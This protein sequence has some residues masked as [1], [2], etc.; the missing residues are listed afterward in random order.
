MN[1]NFGS[2][3]REYGEFPGGERGLLQNRHKHLVNRFFFFKCNRQ[4]KNILDNL[5]A[6][7]D[8]TFNTL[9]GQLLFCQDDVQNLL[10]IFRRKIVQKLLS[11]LVRRRNISFDNSLEGHDDFL[12]TRCKRTFVHHI[13]Q[14]I[15]AKS[16]S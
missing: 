14:H 11:C 15:I 16:Q 6:S 8:E 13:Y 10:P 2:F 3:R 7:E 4:I 1:S 12:S 9:L 5:L